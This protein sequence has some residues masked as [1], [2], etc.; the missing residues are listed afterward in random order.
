MDGFEGVVY[1]ILILVFAFVIVVPAYAILLALANVVYRLASGRFFHW[2][3]W[4][5]FA[6]LLLLFLGCAGFVFY[7]FTRPNAF[8]ITH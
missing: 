1:L 4:S 6:P 2:A 8:V 5:T 7:G 3:R